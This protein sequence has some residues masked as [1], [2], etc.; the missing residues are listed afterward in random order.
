MFGLTAGPVGFTSSASAGDLHV[1]PFPTGEYLRNA[2]LR[3]VETGQ[4]VIS[5]DEGEFRISPVRAGPATV[6]VTYTG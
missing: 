3:I 1:G 4:A 2:Q 5:E 6:V